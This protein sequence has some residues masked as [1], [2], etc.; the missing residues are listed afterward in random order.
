MMIELVPIVIITQPELFQRNVKKSTKHS[1][2]PR[3]KAKTL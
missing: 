2:V 3:L 1:P